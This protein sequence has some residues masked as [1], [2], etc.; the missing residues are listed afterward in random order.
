MDDIQTKI[1]E[2]KMI[3][4]VVAI[5]KNMDVDQRIKWVARLLESIEA[6]IG[7]S[8]LQEVN[9]ILMERFNNGDW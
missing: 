7:E 3:Y 5:L 1:D 2:V 4:D 6:E 9:D 8:G